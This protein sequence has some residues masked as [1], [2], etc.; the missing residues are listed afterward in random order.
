MSIPYTI[1]QNQDANGTG[2]N[3]HSDDGEVAIAVIG[4]GCRLPGGTAPEAF[5]EFCSRG[6][7]AWAPWPKDRFNGEAFLH[8]D[9][10]NQGTVWKERN[11]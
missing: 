1:S 4:I 6:K 2:A 10:E 3:G 5:W 9:P 7:E 11:T 8:P